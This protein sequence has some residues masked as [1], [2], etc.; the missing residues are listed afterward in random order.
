MK[1]LF[2]I[3]IIEIIVLS[4]IGLVG[5]IEAIAFHKKR[6]KTLLMDIMWSLINFLSVGLLI[7]VN[8]LNIK[9]LIITLTILT[10][11]QV[12]FMVEVVIDMVK[13]DFKIGEYKE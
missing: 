5:I 13:R 11:L 7:L 9:G 1:V 3:N 2:I 6:E 4:I 10:G 12:L 8:C